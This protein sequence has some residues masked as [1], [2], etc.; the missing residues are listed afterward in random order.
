[1]RLALGLHLR[2]LQQSV[3]LVVVAQAT[4]ETQVTAAGQGLRVRAV[5]AGR[6]TRTTICTATIRARACAR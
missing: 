4:K 6:F 5:R 3:L 2:V 1:M